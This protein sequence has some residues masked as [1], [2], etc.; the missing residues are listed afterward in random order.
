NQEHKKRKPVN[1]IELHSIHSSDERRSVNGGKKHRTSN[2][3]KKTEFDDAKLYKQISKSLLK[4]N[5]RRAELSCPDGIFIRHSTIPE[6]GKGVFA[7]K[8]FEKNTYFGPYLGVRHSNFKTAQQSGYAW[9]IVDKLGEMVYLIDAY[10]TST[11]NWM[12]YVN[13]PNLPEAQ[14]L[15]PVQYDRN[16]FYKTIRTIFPGEEL[17]VYYGDGYARYLGV[18]VFSE[19][20]STERDEIEAIE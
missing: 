10:E 20:Q 8:K 12:R 9:S 13:C 15:Q 17:F 14:N 18:P 16:M 1:E 6:A 3:E 11:S 7:S 19:V 2:I 5:H 4:N